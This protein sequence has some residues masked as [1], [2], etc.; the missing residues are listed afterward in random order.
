MVTVVVDP[1][2]PPALNTTSGTILTVASGGT[3]AAT[4]GRAVPVLVL[5]AGFWSL[6]GPVLVAVSEITG[7]GSSRSRS[8]TTVIGTA[9]SPG[10]RPLRLVHVTSCPAGAQAQ[11]SP[12]AEERRAPSGILK[13]VVT[14]PSDG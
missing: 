2:V 3:G 10:R 6:P 5:S 9:S 8:R 12:L 4:S 7:P 14:G 13:V 11:P 1:P